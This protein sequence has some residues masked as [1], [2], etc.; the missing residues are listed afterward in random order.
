MTLIEVLIASLLL[1]I[2]MGGICA[3]LIQTR[4]LARATAH[5]AHALQIARSNLEALRKQ[6]GYADPALSDGTHTGLL[7]TCP[8]VYSVDGEVVY[9]DYRSSYAVN[10]TD[11]GDGVSYKT[12]NF[13]VSWDEKNFAGVAEHSVQAN[14]SIASCLNR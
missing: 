13:T 5:R 6:L 3:A 1:M 12:V 2:T 8:Q 10:T 9:V 11:L 4:Y 14:T 7:W